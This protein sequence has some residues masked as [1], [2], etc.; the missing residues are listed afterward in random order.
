MLDYSLYKI[1]DIDVPF[2]SHVYYHHNVLMLFKRFSHEEAAIAQ[3]PCASD[4]NIQHCRSMSS[5]E[6]MWDIETTSAYL[7]ATMAFLL[8]FFLK[9]TFSMPQGGLVGT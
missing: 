2:G 9:L 7:T 8:S 1:L 5:R 4:I 6:F 3:L